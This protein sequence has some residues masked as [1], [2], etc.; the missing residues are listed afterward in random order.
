MR[1]PIRLRPLVGALL[2][3]SLVGSGCSAFADAESDNDRSFGAVVVPSQTGDDPASGAA[4][5]PAVVAERPSTVVV[6][7]DSITVAS[8]DD[9]EVALTG[10]GLEVLLVDAQV[11]RRMTVGERG[12]LVPGADVIRFVSGILEPELWIVALG[13]NDIGQYPEPEQIGEQVSEVLAQVPDGVPVVWVD[14]W[15]RSRPEQSR[16]VNEALREV[17]GRRPGAIVVDWAEHATADG[18]LSS[19]GV[20]LSDGIGRTR[21]AEVVAA[22]VETISGPAPAP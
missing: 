19:D 22:G 13:T 18:V 9:L 11:G 16:V 5:D 2:A 14:T 6:V 1:S 8:A 3:V 7:G 20:H 21:F 17:V 10:V 15:I 12:R 4:A